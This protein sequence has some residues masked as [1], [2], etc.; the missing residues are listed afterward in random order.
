[1]L[2]GS[3]CGSDGTFIPLRSLETGSVNIKGK[4]KG[5]LVAMT[6]YSDNNNDKINVLD[7]SFSVT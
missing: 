5:L 3:T 6:F 1:M 2:G 4:G 7:K